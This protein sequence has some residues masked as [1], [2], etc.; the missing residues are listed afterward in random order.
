MKESELLGKLM[1]GH[2]DILPIIENI[3]EKYRIPDVRPEDDIAEILLT[4]DDI[5]WDA[6]HKDIELQVKNVPLL[7][8]PETKY[9][10]NLKNLQ[11]MPLDF[12]ELGILPEETRNA[13]KTMFSNII[14]SYVP[15]LAII[16]DK[17]YKPLTEI[18]Y[19]YLLT[20][21]TRDVPEDWFGKVATLNFFG[22]PIVMAM[23]GEGAN[24]KEL[25]EQFK[26]EFTKTFG[27]D[28]ANITETHLSTAEYLTMK[29]QGNSLK[30]L[31]ETYRDRHLSEF[32]KNRSSKTYQKAIEKQTELMK[33]R[34]QRLQ[35]VIDK[36]GGDKK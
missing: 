32:P 6:V 2:P 28:R 11:S 17:T 19:E 33:K 3:R 24:P 29:L 23:A 1:P 12:P 8:D 4:R 20:G 25:A 7:D 13:I 10:Q 27:K 5:D 16:D 35:D 21:K 26:G 18:M 9:I 15:M 36:M 14:Q 31:V 34:I 30:N 22:K